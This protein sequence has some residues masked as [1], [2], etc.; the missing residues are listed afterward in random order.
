MIMGFAAPDS[1]GNRQQCHRTRDASGR[2]ITAH[3]TKH[4]DATLDDGPGSSLFPPHWE[5]EAAAE[6]EEE[7]GELIAGGVSVQPW[8]TPRVCE[9]GRAHV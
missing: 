9:I 4:T 7:E 1:E 5:E 6:E 3:G 2:S 8:C